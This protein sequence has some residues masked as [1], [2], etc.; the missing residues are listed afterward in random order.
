[1]LGTGA[2]LLALV[3]SLFALAAPAF[4]DDASATC[5]PGQPL[6]R[7]PGQ[8]PQ[9]P[10]KPDGRP[11]D[12]PPGECGLRIS[13]GSVARGE[14]VQVEGSGYAAGEL[15]ALRLD[16]G[17]H[18]L[19]SVHADGNGAFST[20]VVI[21][22]SATLG[23]NTVL[24]TSATRELSAV[25]EVTPAAAAAAAAAPASSGSSTLPRTGMEIAGLTAVGLLL[26]VAGAF[27]VVTARRRR[28]LLAS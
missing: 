22:A 25:L 3:L 4:A 27:A 14:S 24:A 17:A 13:R 23:Q 19:G 18:D 7:P 16:P 9:T 28:S 20:S 8:N 2:A 5:P 12:Y 1:V 10:G 6:G 11:S 15:V 21:P 26:I